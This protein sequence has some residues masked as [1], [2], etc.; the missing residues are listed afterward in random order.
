MIID[1]QDSSKEA[2]KAKSE[3]AR[4]H[5]ASLDPTRNNRQ[6]TSDNSQTTP[7]RSTDMDR[8][9]IDNWWR[10]LGYFS[11]SC[12][13]RG[14]DRMPG[15]WTKEATK[16]LYRVHFTIGHGAWGHNS[17]EWKPQAETDNVQDTKEAT[18]LNS[19]LVI[20]RRTHGLGSWRRP[21]RI[22]LALGL[23]LQL[24]WRQTNQQPLL[25]ANLAHLRH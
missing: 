1:E 23:T 10:F 9:C 17:P 6:W 19:L 4:C 12:I 14:L 21:A 7:S 11:G 20:S 3:G 13:Y 25:Q 22:V 15:G 24:K 2:H 8:Y 5:S 16:Q 18:P